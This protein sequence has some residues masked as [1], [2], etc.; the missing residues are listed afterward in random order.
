MFVIILLNETSL[1]LWQG[2]AAYPCHKTY[3]I[4]DSFPEVNYFI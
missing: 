2:Y 3:E 4:S 1:V